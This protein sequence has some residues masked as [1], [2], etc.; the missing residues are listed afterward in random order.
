MIG[1]SGEGDSGRPVISLKGDP[2]SNRSVGS[3]PFNDAVLYRTWRDPVDYRG[4]VSAPVA[5]VEVR[6]ISPCRA[7]TMLLAYSAR[8]AGCS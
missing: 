4:H 5:E 3:D 2:T 6:Q 7:S 8:E 1:S